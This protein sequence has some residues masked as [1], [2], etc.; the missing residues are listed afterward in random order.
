MSVAMR[1]DC[2]RHKD[3]KNCSWVCYDKTGALCFIIVDG[4]GTLWSLKFIS[5]GR[6]V[7]GSYFDKLLGV[8]TLCSRIKKHFQQLDE[9]Y[10][11]PSF[12]SMRAAFN[13]VKS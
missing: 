5:N 4:L 11:I 1:P 3:A 8:E 13:Q 2:E 12:L 9:A 6:L 10:V 7:I